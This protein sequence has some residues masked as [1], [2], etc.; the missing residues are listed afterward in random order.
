MSNMIT[1]GAVIRCQTG[2][3]SSSRHAC[4]HYLWVWT[5]VVNNYQLTMCPKWETFFVKFYIM[6]LQKDTI[7]KQALLA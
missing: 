6:E 5:V 2:S 3:G 1:T 4:N 7:G